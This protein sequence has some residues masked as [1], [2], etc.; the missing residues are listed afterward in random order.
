MSI[1]VRTSFGSLSRRQI[2]RDPL[3]HLGLPW[4]RLTSCECI[5]F[6][7][8][9]DLGVL[10]IHSRRCLPVCPW[11]T[12]A[13]LMQL[14]WQDCY[15]LFAKLNLLLEEFRSWSVL[16]A[17]MCTHAC[18]CLWRPDVTPGCHNSAAVRLGFWD[19]VPNWHLGLFVSMV[20]G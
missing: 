6:S 19:R 15:L 1:E 18:V 13:L 3:S 8:L 10:E 2:P 4:H 5:S 11:H 7:I 14:P 17:L 9:T 16:C 20:A 12:A